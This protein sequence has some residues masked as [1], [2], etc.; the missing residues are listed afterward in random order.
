M[1]PLQVLL[2]VALLRALRQQQGLELLAVVGLLLAASPQ[3]FT[4]LQWQMAG[5]TAATAIHSAV[6]GATTGAAV[7]A[8]VGATELALWLIVIGKREA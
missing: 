8:K 3:A 6:V 5:M 4:L 1:F 2:R 7:G